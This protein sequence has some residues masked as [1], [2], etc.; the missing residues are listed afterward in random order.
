MNITP[1][2]IS[3]YCLFDD[4]LKDKRL[5]QRGPQ[6]T[7]IDSEVLTMEI[8]DEFLG[9][10]TDSGIFGYFRRHYG[11]WFPALK[12]IHRTTFVRQAAN[13]WAFK[14]QLWSL[15]IGWIEH[16]PL[17]SI[18]GSMPI[19]VCC[20]TRAHRFRI[21]AGNTAFTRDEVAR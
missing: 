1:F 10:D 15:M 18:T 9:I 19:P 5:C 20:F 6:P 21:L 3:V 16:D 12:P 7:L 17:I 14:R 4:F 2:L 11:D 8:V 13:L